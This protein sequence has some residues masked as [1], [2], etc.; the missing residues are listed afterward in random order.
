[1]V[2]GQ[3]NILFRR[4]TFRIYF[5]V[6]YS[7][8]GMTRVHESLV[9]E[10]T[11]ITQYQEVGTCKI[12]DNSSIWTLDYSM[13]QIK[14]ILHHCEEN[15]RISTGILLEP[16][17]KKVH[18]MLNRNEIL[19]SASGLNEDK[20]GMKRWSEAQRLSH[21]PWKKTWNLTEINASFKRQARRLLR[22]LNLVQSRNKQ[23]NFQRYP[24][25]IRRDGHKR[26]HSITIDTTVV[27]N[28]LEELFRNMLQ[29]AC[30]SVEHT[31]RKS[32]YFR[33]RERS[34]VRRGTQVG[35]ARTNTKSIL[36]NLCRCLLFN[37]T[38]L[39]FL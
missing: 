17:K 13:L 3:S 6:I 16:L 23:S 34:T 2:N 1:M 29:L 15:C 27:K 30:C 4:G 20:N 7:K 14:M 24:R 26:T 22:Q 11:T 19:I 18:T 8:C 12:I 36:V 31:L 35:P 28:S 38:Q 39:P 37:Q 10:L 5:E 32:K 21:W 33:Y 9:N 25:I